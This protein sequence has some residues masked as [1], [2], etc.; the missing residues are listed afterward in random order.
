MKPPTIYD[1]ARAAGVSHQTVTR[2]LHGFEGIRPETRDRVQAAIAELGYLPNA[3]ARQLRQNRVNVIGLL[4]HRVDMPGPA[5]LVVGAIGAARQRGYLIE[6]V[7]TEGQEPDEIDAALGQL[8]EHQHAGLI[9]ETQYEGLTRAIEARDLRVPHVMATSRVLTPGDTMTTNHRSGRMAA[10]H[11]IGLG[12]RDIGYVSGPQSWFVA[13]ER[14]EGFVAELAD[15]GLE[16]VW[17]AEGDWSPASA[18]AAWRDRPRST[19]M[20]A[21]GLGNDSMAIGLV[22]AAT[23]AGVAVPAELSVIGNDDMPEAS[24]VTPS[25]STIALDFE[26]EGAFLV[27]TLLEMITGEPV[28]SALP[29]PRLIVRASSAPVSR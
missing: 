7:V 24:F 20:T 19:A 17:E 15:A 25:L 6:L 9:I 1:V 22:S 14:R 13:R 10:A 23:A 4:A 12:H 26:A 8:L 28:D 5:R 18:A 3:A 29:A 21:V 27:S 2:H 11:L 16:P